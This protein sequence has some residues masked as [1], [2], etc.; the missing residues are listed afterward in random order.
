MRTSSLAPKTVAVKVRTTR[1]RMG[2]GLS[3]A[4]L[5]GQ[6][7]PDHLGPFLAFDHFEMAQPFFPPHP[8]AGFSAVTY[9]LPQSRGGFVNRDSRGNRSLIRPGALHWTQAASGL[10]HEEVPEERGVVCQGMQIFINLPVALKWSEPAVL[11]LEPEQLPR[12]ATEGAEVRVVAG[13]HGATRAPF[14]PGTPVTLLDV[15]LA[16]GGS[17]AHPVPSGERRFAYVI[18]G[19]LELDGQ[20][21]DAGEAVGFSEAGREVRLHSAGG[22]QVLL[23]GGVPLNEPAM[24]YGPFCMSTRED[25]ARAIARYEAGAMGALEASFST[26]GEDR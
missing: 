24:F 20:R 7:L 13:A 9:M 17:V 19:S 16:E 21:V 6:H 10:M 5:H 22:A 23:A 25:I 4:Q 3:I 1:Q 26:E 2:E 18:E 11:H 14:A 8:H 12:V 15:V